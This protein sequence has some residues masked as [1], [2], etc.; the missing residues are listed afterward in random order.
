M[1]TASA[2]ERWAYP[3]H[4]IVLPGRAVPFAV[5]AV[6]NTPQNDILATVPNADNTRFSMPNDV[7]AS[8][9]ASVSLRTIAAYRGRLP[10]THTD[11]A[12]LPGLLLIV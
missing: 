2:G 4:G 8:L 10:G 7:L 5:K 6:R 11:L 3:H 1:L 12:S 9:T